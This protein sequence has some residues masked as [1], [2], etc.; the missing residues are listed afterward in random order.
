VDRAS[1][2]QWFSESL[3]SGALGFPNIRGGVLSKSPVGSSA[4]NSVGSLTMARAMATRCYRAPES[5]L[6]NP[7]RSLEHASTMLRGFRVKLPKFDLTE[8]VAVSG[9]QR[10]SLMDSA[11][12][13]QW[14]TSIPPVQNA[15]TRSAF[16]NAVF[17]ERCPMSGEAIELPPLLQNH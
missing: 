3:R 10:W 11:T 16:Q 9:R 15:Q 5:C 8:M 13:G 4:S 6:G 2:S 14:S 17:P 12:T 1:P 7:S